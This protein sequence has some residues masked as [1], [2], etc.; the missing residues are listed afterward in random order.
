MVD[1]LPLTAMDKVDRRALSA[2]VAERSRTAE[3]RE[4]P[5]RGVGGAEGD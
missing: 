3:G 4:G 5:D 1:A 2:L